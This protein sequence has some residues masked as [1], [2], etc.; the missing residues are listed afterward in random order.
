M[1]DPHPDFG[2]NPYGSSMDGVDLVFGQDP[3]RLEEVDE[4]TISL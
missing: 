1:E 4:M 3:R 2:Q